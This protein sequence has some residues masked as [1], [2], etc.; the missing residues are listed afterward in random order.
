MPDS[1]EFFR[2][3]IHPW[4]EATVFQPGYGLIPCPEKAP[5]TRIGGASGRFEALKEDALEYAFLL[6]LEGKNT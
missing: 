5:W 2:L 3:F 4:I 6:D 1:F